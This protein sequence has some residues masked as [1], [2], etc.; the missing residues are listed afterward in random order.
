[1]TRIG[2]GVLWETVRLIWFIFIYRCWISDR[3]FRDLY[4]LR[5]FAGGWFQRQDRLQRPLPN[6]FGKARWWSRIRWEDCYSK[7]MP[8]WCCWDYRICS[9]K[10]NC[11]QQTRHYLIFSTESPHL[12]HWHNTRLIHSDNRLYRHSYRSRYTKIQITKLY[13]RLS[14]LLGINGVGPV[15]R[16]CCLIKPKPVHPRYAVVRLSS[17]SWIDARKSSYSSQCSCS[18]WPCIRFWR[19]LNQYT[20][21]WLQDHH[22]I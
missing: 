13:P 9:V 19:N 16:R 17:H 3:M 11:K 6:R 22:S 7:I 2:W 10:T 15:L 4:M 20:W 14:L 12:K 21:Q 8:C 18:T 5:L 1:M